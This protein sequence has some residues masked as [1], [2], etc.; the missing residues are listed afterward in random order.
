MKYLVYLH[1]NSKLI[2]LHGLYENELKLYKE[3]VQLDDDFIKPLK[4]WKIQN[5][6]FPV[7]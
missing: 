2:K 3:M 7:L 4:W 6:K 1:I 5:T